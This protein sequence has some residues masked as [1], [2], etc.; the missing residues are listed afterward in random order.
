M[1]NATATPT[2]APV[3]TVNMVDACGAGVTSNHVVPLGQPRSV[4]LPTGYRRPYCQPTRGD[5]PPSSELWRWTTVLGSIPEPE[6]LLD[7]DGKALEYLGVNEYA[8]TWRKA[9]G[10]LLVLPALYPGLL[11][12]NE[13]PFRLPVGPAVGPA[14]VWNGGT[15]QRI[16]S[17][18]QLELIEVND[19]KAVLTLPSPFITVDKGRALHLNQGR[20]AADGDIPAHYELVDPSAGTPSPNTPGLQVGLPLQIKTIY[21]PIGATVTIVGFLL[22]QGRRFRMA[23][24]TYYPDNQPIGVLSDLPVESFVD[25][26][27]HLLTPIGIRGNAFVWGNPDGTQ[28]AVPALYPATYNGVSVGAIFLCPNCADPGILANWQVWLVDIKTGAPVNVIDHPVV[29]L[30]KDEA[31]AFDQ[32]TGGLEVVRQ[33]Q[34]STPPTGRRVGLPLP[35]VGPVGTVEG[36]RLFNFPKED[37]GKFQS[38]LGWMKTVTP[39]WYQYILD[40]RPTDITWNPELANLGVGGITKCCRTVGAV[41]DSALIELSDHPPADVTDNLYFLSTLVHETTHV[42]DRRAKKFQGSDVATCRAVERSAVEQERAFASDLLNRPIDAK[43]RANAQRLLQFTEA[44]LA[45]GTFDW[46]AA[47]RDK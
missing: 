17:G 44:E 46:N 6:S 7:G 18:W 38:A 35:S 45:K 34:D 9:D 26:T 23:T 14:L 31:I 39:Q 16:V 12:E 41:S 8:F 22:V 5:F 27:G 21:N 43:T 4:Y 15:D 36:I 37:V 3:F 10:D 13:S 42:R 29:T 40:A 33:E 19:N 28:L 11:V 1:P 25:T 20:T 30:G 24:A 47:C 2:A 32:T